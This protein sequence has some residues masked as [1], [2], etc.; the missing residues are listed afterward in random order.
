MDGIYAAVAVGVRPFLHLPTRAA[1]QPRDGRRFLPLNRQHHRP[2][3]ITPIGVLLLKDASSQLRQ[4]AGFPLAYVHRRPPAD[5][6]IPHNQPQRKRHLR[7]GGARWS[8]G[9]RYYSKSESSETGRSR[10]LAARIS[11][12]ACSTLA[13]DNI[14]AP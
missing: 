3:T 6:I 10:P 9:I 2:H 1:Q 14:S 5:H 12:T 11:L 13:G 8:T 4:L 7:G